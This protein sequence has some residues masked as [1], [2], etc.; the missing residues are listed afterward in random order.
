MPHAKHPL[1]EVQALILTAQ[2]RRDDDRRRGTFDNGT[3]K[4]GRFKKPSGWTLSAR[5][6][7]YLASSAPVQPIDACAARRR[8]VGAQNNRPIRRSPCSPSLPTS[9]VD[10]RARPTTNMQSDA[11]FSHPAVRVQSLSRCTLPSAPA[12]RTPANRVC[13]SSPPIPVASPDATAG[14]TSTSPAEHHETGAQSFCTAA[15]RS[16]ANHSVLD[17]H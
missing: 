2:G 6:A 7:N 17:H 3:R 1:R 13:T 12:H 8:A 16:F 10:H 9:L 11:S 15:V 5:A 14:S 4:F